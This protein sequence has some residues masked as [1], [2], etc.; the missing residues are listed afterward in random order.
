MA[1]YRRTV[2]TTGLTSAWRP[3][4]AV[5]LSLGLCATARSLGHH[6]AAPT[7]STSVSPTSQPPVTTGTTPPSIVAMPSSSPSLTAASAPLGGEACQ[8]SQLSVPPPLY[9]AAAG[10]AL[11]TF[12]V[13]NVSNAACQLGG[14]FG[15]SLYDPSGHLLDANSGR[16][17]DMPGDP[18]PPTAVPFSPSSQA[19]FTV[20]VGENP[21][22]DATSC[23]LIGAFHLI[24]PNSRSQLKVALPQAAN[25][26]YWFC[27]SGI[28]VGPARLGAGPD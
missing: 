11:Y 16:R 19:H 23:P 4:L 21:P 18:G 24:P 8:P 28:G 25:Q 1:R 2:S 5:T 6:S 12:H 22:G 15:V 27:G 17:T 26:K 20:S 13:R 9:S 14:Y 10:T 3:L 7:T